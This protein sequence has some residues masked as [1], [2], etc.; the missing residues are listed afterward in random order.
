MAFELNLDQFGTIIDRFGRIPRPYRVALIPLTVVLV[1][2]T[3]VYFFYGPARTERRSLQTQER[4][5]Q[6]QVSEVQAIVSNLPA[7]E[8][9]LASME[10]SLRHAL[11]RLPDSKELPVLL[12]DVSTIGK[13]A[14]LEMKVFRPGDEVAR[15]F[16]AEVPIQIEFSGSFHDIARFFD[17]IAK[18]DRIVNIGELNM[19]IST[20][21]SERTVL[22]VQGEATTFR[23]LEGAGG[24]PGSAPRAG[25][26][27]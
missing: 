17:R 21:S 6:Q 7:F 3:Y 2:A 15:D 5:L 22:R 26:R 11:L 20:Q 19:S 12:T 4:Q 23:F 13:R 10:R 25:G 18:L 27:S 9:E 24:G 1:V 8:E 16:Y 14:G